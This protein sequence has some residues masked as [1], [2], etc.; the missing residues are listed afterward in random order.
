MRANKLD[1]LKE[2]TLFRNG[3]SKEELL[4][5]RNYNTT[6]STAENRELTAKK[7]CFVG[8]MW[9]YQGDEQADE[10]IQLF[11]RGL[12]WY[13]HRGYLHGERKILHSN[14]Y[15]FDCVFVLEYYSNQPI[16]HIPN[17][18]YKM[19]EKRAPISLKIDSQFL[20][21]VSQVGPLAAKIIPVC[22]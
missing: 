8:K 9:F 13:V 6:V 2:N 20:Q 7:L 15:R 3:K 10:R 16:F 4:T 18:F 21:S 1:F 19:F 14:N 22:F 17:S 11:S 5:K 12:S